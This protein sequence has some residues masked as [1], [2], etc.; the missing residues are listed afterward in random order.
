MA[1]RILMVIHQ[2]TKTASQL[3][4]CVSTKTPCRPGISRL[5]HRRNRRD[6]IHLLARV[7]A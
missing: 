7:E 2:L 6:D 3:W 4:P 1:V 5:S